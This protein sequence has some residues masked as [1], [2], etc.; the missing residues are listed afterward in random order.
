MSDFHETVKNLTPDR[1]R[2]STRDLAEE[3]NKLYEAGDLGEAEVEILRD[4]LQGEGKPDIPLVGVPHGDFYQRLA[5]KWV[6]KGTNTESV[7]EDP[8]DTINL[9]TIRQKNHDFI[10]EQ[11]IE[12]FPG[13]HGEI[14]RDSIEC[15]DN[16]FEPMR[17]V[18][19]P[20]M[21]YAAARKK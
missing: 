6:Q 21:K 18:A 4:E 12:N 1:D 9:Y 2:G 5:Y 17:K 8:H 19:A 15:F 16:T 20:F 14:A 10:E 3:V 11:H 13:E 7:E